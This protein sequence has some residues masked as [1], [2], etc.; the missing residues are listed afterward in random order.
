MVVPLR[1][2][3]NV[4]YH[5]DLEPLATTVRAPVQ[6]G[7]GDRAN[8]I[9]LDAP[10]YHLDP[11]LFRAVN[12]GPYAGSFYGIGGAIDDA[13]KISRP[14][15]LYNRVKELGRVRGQGLVYEAVGEMDVFEKWFGH[16]VPRGAT[17]RFYRFM[18]TFSAVPLPDDDTRFD[19]S[20]IRDETVHI[21]LFRFIME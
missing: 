18:E 17:N 21:S 13:I 19:V 14:D 12:P 16:S 1:Q 6:R 7:Q 11:I 15:T 3:L 10:L 4:R 8:A 5:H 9:N 2:A 20:Q